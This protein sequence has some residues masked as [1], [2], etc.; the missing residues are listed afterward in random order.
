M[1]TFLNLVYLKMSTIFS[2]WLWKL[3]V[4]THGQMVRRGQFTNLP[5][6]LAR[7]AK[8]AKNCTG[9]ALT[10]SYSLPLEVHLKVSHRENFKISW[11]RDNYPSRE[12][13]YLKYWTLKLYIL[14]WSWCIFIFWS[15]VNLLKP[16]ETIK[17]WKIYEI[18]LV[19]CLFLIN[20]Y[21]C[22]VN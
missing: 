1:A 8:A 3:Y 15:S 6:Q 17:K 9:R 5:G 12:K 16:T 22:K 7:V 21:L 20:D 13:W 18:V 11:R 10:H 4:V 19:L 14:F 2:R